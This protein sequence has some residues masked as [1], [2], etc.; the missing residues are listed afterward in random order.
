MKYGR[1]IGLSGITENRQPFQIPR[2][3]IISNHR[4]NRHY[5][6]RVLPYIATWP[7]FRQG[8]LSLT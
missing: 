2:L 5:P 8:L 1:A 7:S 6:L 3:S 4:Q